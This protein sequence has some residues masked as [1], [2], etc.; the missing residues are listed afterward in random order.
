[1]SKTK[2]EGKDK[3]KVKDDEKMRSPS[4]ALTEERLEDIVYTGEQRKALTVP[5]DEVL[6][7]VKKQLEA[8]NAELSFDKYDEV[9]S[10]T[11]NRLTCYIK[12]YLSD[13]IVIL[14]SPDAK[15][16][17]KMDLKKIVTKDHIE[18]FVKQLKDTNVT[19]LDLTGNDLKDK[20]AEALVNTLKEEG[21]KIT[22]LNLM[23]NKLKDEGA[24][25][26]AEA[27]EK[28]R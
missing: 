11:P 5:S 28:K 1:M 16:V 7:N 6:N 8:I 13:L 22:N 27:L 23:D 24:R 3:E 25:A 14:K 26:I 17:T 10:V 9:Y 12:T 2:E 18:N 21:N 19:A 15:F 20:G 4:T